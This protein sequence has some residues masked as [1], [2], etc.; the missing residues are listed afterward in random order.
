MKP[1]LC[2][3]C[4][5]L[6]L[7]VGACEAQSEKDTKQKVKT[8]SQVL[9]EKHI[10]D[11]EGKR[12]GLLMNPA[13]RVNGVHMVDTLLSLGVNITVL[14]SPEHGFRG[15]AGAGEKIHDGID[16]LTGL[17]VYSL[18]GEHRKP[19][20]EMLK[21]IDILLFDLPDVGARFFTYSS[22]LGLVIEA[23]AETEKEIWVLDRPN[24]LGGDY[25]T[26]WLLRDEYSSFVGKYPVPVASGLT[27]AELANMAIGEKWLTLKDKPKIKYIKAEGWNRQMKWPETGLTWIPPSPNLPAFENLQM[28]LG[29]VIFEGTNL[30]EGRGTEYPFLMFG[31]PDFIFEDRELDEMRHKYNIGLTKIEFTPVSVPGKASHP[32]YENELCNGIKIEVHKTDSV[33]AL[34]LGIDLLQFAKA[35]TQSFEITNFANKLYGIDIKSIIEKNQ[36][37]PGWQDDVA[38]FKSQRKPYLFYD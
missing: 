13:T 7:S 33:D 8:G 15:N 20:P 14:F 26:G 3:V 10:H 2:S 16:E 25:V 21:E 9:L 31:A 23:I 6:L 4:I 1:G 11:L 5:L 35:H 30:S 27:M 36:M 18:Y 19:T 12:V 32:K 28:Y 34:A 38:R 22:T 24:P 37:V 17:P 29:T